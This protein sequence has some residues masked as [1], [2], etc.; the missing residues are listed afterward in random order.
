MIG[1]FR[2]NIEKCD[3]CEKCVKICS[4]GVFDIGEDEG[5]VVATIAH[6]ENCDNCGKCFTICSK[7]SIE[8]R[9]SD[10]KP[11]KKVVGVDKNK[12]EACETCISVCPE[13]NFEIVEKE[14][15]IFAKVKNPDLCVCDGHCAFSCKAK[16]KPQI[17]EEEI[18]LN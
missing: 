6:I 3:A 5:K 14:G 11:F 8:L 1:L 17:Y 13:H 10:D 12:C 7:S 4:K 16:I 18:I 15:K 2:I 9:N